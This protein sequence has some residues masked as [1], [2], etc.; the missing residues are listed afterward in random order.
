MIVLYFVAYFG[1]LEGLK[2]GGKSFAYLNWAY[3]MSVPLSKHYMIGRPSGDTTI[4]GAVESLM[5]PDI[6]ATASF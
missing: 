1:R 5:V 4:V 2:K 3:A 6:A